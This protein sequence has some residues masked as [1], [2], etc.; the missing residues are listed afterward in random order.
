[1]LSLRTAKDYTYI[2]QL[3]GRMVR[4]PLARRITT[5][6]VLNT[7]AL[8]LPYYREDEV[9]KVV[10]GI[11]SD[12]SQLSSKVEINPVVCPRSATIPPATWPLLE[13][14]P[15]YTRPAKNHRHETARLNG[16]ATLLVGAELQSDAMEVAKTHL[17]DTLKR[18]SKRLGLWLD[19][20]VS[21]L[22]QL[23][24]QI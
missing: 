24:Y 20:K 22:A 2:A 17:V 6:D 9:K 14:V 3:I 11:E 15:T 10:A 16:L 7:V 23:D 21:D 19:Q 4:T 1:M 12:D 5:D 8:Y 18:E 13:D